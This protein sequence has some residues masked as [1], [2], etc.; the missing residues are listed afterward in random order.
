MNRSIDRRIEALEAQRRKRV[1]VVEQLHCD[2][3]EDVAYA[4]HYAAHPVDRDAELTVF[5]RSFSPLAS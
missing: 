3:P 5:I 4:R 1:A 2:E